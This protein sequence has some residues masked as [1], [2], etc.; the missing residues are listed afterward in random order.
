MD[1]V[2]WQVFCRYSQGNEFWISGT[3]TDTFSA[4]SAAAELIGSA[5]HEGPFHVILRDGR[6]AKT[7]WE[8]DV[9]ATCS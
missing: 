1:G 3:S 8:V 7:L 6:S 4:W 9:V 2:T 5:L